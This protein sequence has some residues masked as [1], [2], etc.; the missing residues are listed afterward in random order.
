MDLNKFLS[1]ALCSPHSLEKP[2][3]G[4][5]N[6]SAIANGFQCDLKCDQTYTFY[7]YPGQAVKTLT[8]STGSPW[9][10]RIPACTPGKLFGGYCLP[11]TELRGH[12]NHFA[13]TIC[14]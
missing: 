2:S 3:F 10:E 5:K 7:K 4:Q 9:S 11:E 14:Y 12:L 6:C 8:C 1:A 13:S